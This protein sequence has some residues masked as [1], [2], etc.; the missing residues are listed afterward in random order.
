[1]PHTLEQF[2]SEIVDSRLLSL[3]D[4]DDTISGLPENRRPKDSQE[5]RVS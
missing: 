5:L 1:M 3:A 2:R 4:L